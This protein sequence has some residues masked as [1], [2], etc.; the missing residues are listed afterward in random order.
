MGVED[1]RERAKE[2]G[3]AREGM[4]GERHRQSER[5]EGCFLIRDNSN[6]VRQNT[7]REVKAF[8]IMKWRIQPEQGV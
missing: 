2:R 4:A 8:L 3:V 6:V 1:E 5:Y 7:S